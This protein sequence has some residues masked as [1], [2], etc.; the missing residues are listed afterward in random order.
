MD[1]KS[2][3]RKVFALLRERPDLLWHHCRRSDACDGQAGFPDLIVFG[4]RVFTRE[5]KGDE[6]R[7]TLAQLD[8]GD[9]ITAAGASWGVWRPG[10]LASGRI[11]KEIDQL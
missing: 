3:Q 8:Y 6:T 2:L 4:R 9:V 11:Q 7:T 10:D 5:L 1:E